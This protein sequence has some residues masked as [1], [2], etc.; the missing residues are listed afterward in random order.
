[1]RTIESDFR[2]HG[3]RCAATIYLP[4]GGPAPVV[5]MAHGF[6]A[7]RDFR[8]PAFAEKFVEKGLAVLLFDYRNFGESDGAPRNLVSPH[9]HL[10]DWAAA[11]GHARGL[12][13]VDTTKMALW[14]TSF[15]GGH[16]LVTAARNPWVSAVVSQVPFVDGLAV[17][18]STPL[19]CAT[20]GIVHGLRD[21]SRAVAQAPPHYVPVV[22]EPG[23]F[24]LMSTPDSLPG[25]MA[26]V[27]AG[28]AWENRAPARIELTLPLYRPVRYATRIR[29]PVLI[30]C[31]EKDSLIGQASVVKTAR[32]IRD[33][34]LVRLPVGHFDVYVGEEFERVADL[35]G[36]FLRDR[37]GL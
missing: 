13:Q 22:T 37:L 27:P 8:L 20:E 15:S 32:R 5:V 28:S 23:T 34:K 9:R 2:S 29:C 1:M 33:C 11:I 7:Q 21:M 18:K 4:E 26:L 17:A 10:Q 14:G 30:V 31:A 6:A 25:Y 16:V 3:T 12:E 19:K 35:E 36:D 24:G